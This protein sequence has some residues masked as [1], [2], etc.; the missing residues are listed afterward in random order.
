MKYIGNKFRLLNFIEESMKDFGVPSKGIF[1]DLFSGSTSVAQ[2]F[3]RTYKIISNDFM[4]YSYIYQKCLI[5]NNLAPSFGVLKRE[6]G[7]DPYVFLNKLKGEKGYFFDN[8]N[9]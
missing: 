2:H 6:L 9:K 5:E 4:Y 7:E 8:F 1:I 3:K